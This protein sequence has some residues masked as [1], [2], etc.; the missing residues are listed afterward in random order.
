[1]MSEDSNEKNKNSGTENT[2]KIHLRKQRGEIVLVEEKDVLLAKSLDHWVHVLV[3]RGKKY[4]WLYDHKTLGHF[5]DHLPGR[6]LT[7]CRRFYGVN[8]ARVTQY[9]SKT[10]TLEFDN[11]FTVQLE[12]PLPPYFI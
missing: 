4:E 12:H 6:K 10:R 7:R 11:E 1:M 2:G 5:L 8:K 9:I 3:K